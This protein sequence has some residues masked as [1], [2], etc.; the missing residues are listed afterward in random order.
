M[1]K[2]IA[3]R[4]GTD[5]YCTSSV[6]YSSNVTLVR[7]TTDRKKRFKRLEID[8]GRLMVNGPENLPRAYDE[9]PKYVLRLILAEAEKVQD[10]E[11]SFYEYDRDG[12]ERRSD[13]RYHELDRFLYT[14]NAFKAD[15][16]KRL[17]SKQ[18]SAS[19]PC[20]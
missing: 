10:H 4:F 7:D 12:N 19:L 2:V 5:A 15:L 1:P 11:W 17:A 6:N 20:G 9:C 13:Y 3:V 8:D 16:K 14:I 18:N